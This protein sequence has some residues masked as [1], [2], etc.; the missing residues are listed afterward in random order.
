MVFSVIGGDIRQICIARRLK[1][2]GYTV[3][4]FGDGADLTDCTKGV[5]VIIL[6]LPVTSD[7]ITVKNTSITFEELFTNI[8]KKSIIFG[9]N[10]PNIINLKSPCSIIDYYKSEKLKSK[11]AYLTAEGAIPYII[12]GTKKSL[13]DCKI[14][15]CGFGRIAKC[16]AC[17]LKPFADDVTV[18]LRSRKDMALVSALSFKDIDIYS[19][20]DLS[21]YDV[22]VNTVPARILEKGIETVKKECYILELASPPYGFDLEKANDLNFELGSSLPGKISPESAGIEILN[23]ILRHLER[24]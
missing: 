13:K 11:N 1:E 22:I 9:G 14:L 21:E 24:G 23:C 17:L 4:V 18:A 7:G 19:I 15:I 8:N 12:N 2:K 16:L 20:D 5:D 10:I 6:P 3:K